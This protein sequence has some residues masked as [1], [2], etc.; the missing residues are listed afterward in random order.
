MPLTIFDIKGKGIVSGVLAG[1]CGL[2]CH[3]VARLAQLFHVSPAIFYPLR[4]Q[5]LPRKGAV[6][7]DHRLGVGQGRSS[8][9]QAVKSPTKTLATRQKHPSRKSG[10]P[11]PVR[12]PAT[13]R[14]IVTTEDALVGPR[15]TVHVLTD[16]HVLVGDRTA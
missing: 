4:P 12:S 5:E 8:G 14:N 10:R 7:P 13:S 16:A 11:Q 9:L 3:Y 1:R 6:D 15:Q 2:T